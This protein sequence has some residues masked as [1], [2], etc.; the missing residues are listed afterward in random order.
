M[1]GIDCA[2]PILPQWAPQLRALGYG[3]FARYY[4][5]TLVSRWAVSPEEAKPLFAAGLY[6]LSVFQNTSNVASYFTG[7]AGTADAHAALAKADQMGQ[8]KGTAIYFAVDCD[9]G[10]DQIDMI[11][12]YFARVMGIV[13]VGGYVVGGYGSGFVLKTL[14]SRNLIE[15]AW[16]A[17]AMGWQGSRAFTGWHVK[18]SSLP[19]TLPFGL[20]VDANECPDPV[21][22]GM[23]RPAMPPMQQQ[24]TSLLARIKGWFA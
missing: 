12:D 1:K 22:A 16:L 23:W 11:C 10:P 13:T 2:A 17:N 6:M 7:A 4:R 18:Q 24:P 14:L 5:R 8:P 15:R 19:F 21:A 3:F 9:P 20:Q